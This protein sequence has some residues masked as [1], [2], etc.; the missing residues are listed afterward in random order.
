MTAY[1]SDEQ[2]FFL[3]DNGNRQVRLGQIRGMGLWG[4]REEDSLFRG[5]WMARGNYRIDWIEKVGIKGGRIN[6][7]WY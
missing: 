7:S 4:R 1:L 3:R 6:L 2:S 5:M